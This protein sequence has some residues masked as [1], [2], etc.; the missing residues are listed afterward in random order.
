VTVKAHCEDCDKLQTIVPT[1]KKR[2]EGFSAEFWKVVVHFVNGQP[3]PGSD[4]EV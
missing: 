1:G 3:C 2:R 4:K